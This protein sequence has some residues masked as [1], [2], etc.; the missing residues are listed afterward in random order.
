MATLK[1]RT[2]LGD[3]SVT[4][5]AD[6]APATCKYFERLARQGVLNN[7]SIFRITSE[8]NPVVH[9]DRHIH[10]VQLGTRKGLDEKCELIKHEST[11]L[12]G[13][14][15][16]LWTVSAARFAP[17]ELYRSFFVCMREEPQLDF[18]GNRRDDRL[19]YAAFGQIATGTETLQ[20]IFCHAQTTEILVPPID[21]LDVIFN[22]TNEL[23]TGDRHDE[24]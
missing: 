19:G 21:V 2:A 16:R 8:K 23:P 3:F 7:G 9:R 20:T 22:G 6:R 14:R 24:Q 11:E 15:H 12:S 1:V 13:L 10:V 17:G 18:G 4:L 5:H